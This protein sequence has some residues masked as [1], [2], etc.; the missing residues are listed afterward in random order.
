MLKVDPYGNRMTL[1]QVADIYGITRERVR[2]LCGN[3]GRKEPL[4]KERLE[5]KK[6]YWRKRLYRKKDVTIKEICELYGLCI[7]IVMPIIGKRTEY[8][9][10]QG[11][12]SCVVCDEVKPLEDFY[13]TGGF[14]MSRCKECDKERAVKW[15]K[16]HSSQ[17]D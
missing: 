5:K 4:A 17:S 15:Q 11:T 14:Y 7:G 1:Q 3:V 13:P 9:R 8:D 2:Q 6:D 10:E 16:E 12:R